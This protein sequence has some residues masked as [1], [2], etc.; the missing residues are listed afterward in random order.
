MVWTKFTD[1]ILPEKPPSSEETFRQSQ[2]YS[3]CGRPSHL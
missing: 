2:P 1:A 3:W